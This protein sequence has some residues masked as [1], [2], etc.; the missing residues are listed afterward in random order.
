MPQNA[1]SDP[2][3]HYLSLIQLVLDTSTG[4]EMVLFK[5]YV[6]WIEVLRCPNIKG[7]YGML[8]RFIIS[9]SFQI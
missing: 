8:F 7:K 3:L 5:F 9:F 2:G 6:K 1:Q 4:C